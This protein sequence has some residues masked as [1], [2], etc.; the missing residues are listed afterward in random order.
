MDLECGICS[1]ALD[2]PVAIGAL[3]WSVV[4]P[5]VLV[6][7]GTTLVPT[8]IVVGLLLAGGLFLLGLLRFN[9]AALEAEPADGSAFRR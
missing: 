8:L 6:T 5:F 3:A 9:G 7:L 2:L 1:H 4:S